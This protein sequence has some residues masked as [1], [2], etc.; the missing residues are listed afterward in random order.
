MRQKDE[1]TEKDDQLADF[2]DRLLDGSPNPAPA[3]TR[4]EELLKLEQTL[5][6]LSNAFPPEP[7]EESTAR[8]MLARFKARARKEER[9][10]KPGLWRRLFDFQSNPQ[11]GLILAG[12]A[13]LVLAVVILPGSDVSSSSVSGTASAGVSMAAIAGFVAILLFAYWW[14]R[15]R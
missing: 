7:L 12:F 1:H 10:A 11:V 6:R 3:S 5:L 13:A 14:S 8:Q 9:A 15:R 2:T 4:D